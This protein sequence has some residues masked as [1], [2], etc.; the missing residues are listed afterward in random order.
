MAVAAAFPRVRR[1]AQAVDAAAVGSLPAQP[2][3]LATAVAPCAGTSLQ[4]T[5]LHSPAAVR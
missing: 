2:G 1:V 5:R 4:D 3:A